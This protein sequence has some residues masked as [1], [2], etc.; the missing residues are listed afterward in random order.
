M[1]DLSFGEFIIIAGVT[2]C[3]IKPEDL[4]EIMRTFSRW[5]HKIRTT[6]REFINHIEEAT[7]VKEVR[8][9]MQA[10]TGDDGLQYAAYD[11]A[12]LEPFY[13]AAQ[14][15]I[16]IPETPVKKPRKSVKTKK[17]QVVTKKVTAKKPIPKKAPNR[18]P[19]KRSRA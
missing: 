10:I 14:T 9:E 12:D 19:V 7:G 3:F 16:A 13:R 1:F 18:K 5:S 6:S 11:V 4:P 17:K 2:L 8:A 15:P